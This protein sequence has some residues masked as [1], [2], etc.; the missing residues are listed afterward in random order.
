MSAA[1]FSPIE[2]GDRSQEIGKR[3]VDLALALILGIAFTPIL[4]IIYLAIRFNSNGPGLYRHTRIGKNGQCFDVFKFR[5][6]VINSEEVLTA[7]LG[8]NPEAKVEWELTRKL[9]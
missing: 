1:V 6:M 3:V 7:H 5:T 9:K 4:L 2:I 8:A